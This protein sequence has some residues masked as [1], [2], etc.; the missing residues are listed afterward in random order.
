MRRLLLVLYTVY[1]I[2][3]NVVQHSVMPVVGCTPEWRKESEEEEEEE[4]KEER[5]G[6][7]STGRRMTR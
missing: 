7:W 6:F 3:R 5:V 4:E 2:E 1:A